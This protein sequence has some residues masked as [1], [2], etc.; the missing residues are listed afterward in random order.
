MLDRIHSSNHWMIG[1]EHRERLGMASI[2]GI[3][4]PRTLMNLMNRKNISTRLTRRPCRIQWS[5]QATSCSLR[6]RFV[7]NVYSIAGANILRQV[8]ILSEMVV[9]VH[10]ASI[11]FGCT[12]IGG[13]NPSSSCHNI[14]PVASTNTCMSVSHR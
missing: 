7:Q 11:L 6:E 8:S 1:L 12:L 2:P 3:A 10:I 5:E 14:R 13:P 4:T 9:V